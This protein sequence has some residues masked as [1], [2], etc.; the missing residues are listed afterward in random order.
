ME[1]YLSGSYGSKHFYKGLKKAV[2]IDQ[3]WN[4]ILWRN[5]SATLFEKSSDI[6]ADII[7]AKIIK[8]LELA[9][10]TFHHVRGALPLL[11]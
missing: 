3:M 2:I 11:M 9:G 7:K 10:Y 5:N 8:R 6:E 4:I 1:Y